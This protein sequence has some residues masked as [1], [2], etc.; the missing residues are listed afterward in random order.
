[1]RRASDRMRF[2]QSAAFS[3]I[4]GVAA[5][6]ASLTADRVTAAPRSSPVATLPSRGSFEM[7]GARARQAVTVVLLIAVGAISGFKLLGSTLSVLNAIC[8]LL[9]PALLIWR[10]SLGQWLPLALAVIGF[11]ASFASSQI[12]HVSP[13]GTSS[14]DPGVLQYL[15]FATYYV[16]FLVLAG[17]DLERACSIL[18]GLGIGTV[19]YYL[20]P[21][22]L[23]PNGAVA[24]WSAGQEFGFAGIFKY[25]FGQ[26]TVIILVFL[27]IVLKVAVPLQAA[28]LVLY[29]GFSLV[30]DFRSLATN[31]VAAAVILLAGWLFAGKITRWLQLTIAAVFVTV[32]Y[33]LVLKIVASGLAG[34]AVRHKT[35]AQQAASAGVPLLLAGRAESPLSISAFLDRPWFGW[36]TANNISAHS[37]DRAIKL[38]VSLGFDP[39]YPFEQAWYGETSDVSL[40]SVLLA[41]G[42][43]GGV[44][45]ILLPL[46][47]L[48]A[49]VTIIFN[50]PRYGR[51]AALA[52]LVSVLAVWDLPFSPYGYN[53]LSEY[54]I[55]AVLFGARHLPSKVGA[56]VRGRAGSGPI[57]NYP[58]IA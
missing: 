57:S 49:A 42:A 54:A 12:N 31:C 37:F 44:F 25:A 35:E 51:W 16:G 21:G 50:A 7:R 5:R 53:A 20:Q 58:A 28:F 23:P 52:V 27:L 2:L 46:G 43:D 29:G 47:L 36:G 18:C 38:A 11:V 32:T 41:A 30:Q 19:I 48:V 22:R 17:R 33:T 3:A 6:C 24:D 4:N 45:A 15:S 34:D 9:A 40:H 1:M 26:W 14:T 56:E 39:S 55:L 10:P 8:L 13:F